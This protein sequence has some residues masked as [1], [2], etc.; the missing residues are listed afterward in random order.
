MKFLIP[1]L[2]FSAQLGLAQ[3]P[4]PT[5]IPFP[6]PT[7]QPIVSTLRPY[8]EVF[9]DDYGAKGNNTTG[10][11]GFPTEDSCQGFKDALAAIPPGGTL[12][13]AKCKYTSSCSLVVDKEITIQGN[14]G[15]LRAFCGIGFKPNVSGLVLNETTTVRDLA[16]LSTSY[17]IKDPT[18]HGVVMKRRSRLYDL[19]IRKFPGNGVHID[20]AGVNNNVWLIQGG[21]IATNLG[22][23]IYT[24]GAD[25][26]AGMALGVS[27]TDNG[28]YGVYEDSFLG[29]AYIA[30]HTDANKL[31]AIMNT[32]SGNNNRSMYLHPY[33]EDGT[34]IVNNPR[35]MFI[36]GIGAPLMEGQGARLSEG[37]GGFTAHHFTAVSKGNGGSQV[38]LTSRLGGLSEGTGSQ[39]YANNDVTPLSTTFSVDP[40]RLG[41]FDW[42]YSSAGTPVMSLSTPTSAVGANQIQLHNGFL[43]GPGVQG[44]KWT[45]GTAPPV[46]CRRACDRVFNS[47]VTVSRVSSWVCT[48]A[49]NP[50]T[51]KAEGM[52]SE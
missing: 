27:V 33:T 4:T 7:P 12:R 18:A 28:G 43:M 10:A 26:N 1:I 17:P 3:T 38:P 42:R 46:D 35:G 13:F 2:L 48:K 32:G 36:G 31:G 50:G 20:S 16:I 25:S 37:G 44:C 8:G 23:G 45:Q 6:S 47:A 15:T 5:P 34:K 14:G 19:T 29:N 49:G 24:R 9:V 39:M 40:A 41:W 21:S 52:I 51:W 30:I 22:H 11:L